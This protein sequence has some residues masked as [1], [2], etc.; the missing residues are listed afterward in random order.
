MEV[1]QVRT[2]GLEVVP[3]AWH[4]VEE[5]VAG[6]HVRLSQ[7]RQRYTSYFRVKRLGMDRNTR[8]LGPSLSFSLS[9]RNMS[10]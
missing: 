1:V 4:E 9:F 3:E 7:K 10:Q 2:A 6:D 8:N 5:V